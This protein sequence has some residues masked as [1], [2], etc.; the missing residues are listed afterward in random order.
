MQVHEIVTDADGARHGTDGVV[1]VSLLDAGGTMFKRRAIKGVGGG[2][3]PQQVSWL[4]CE[5]NGVRVYQHGENIV[6]TTQD[7]YP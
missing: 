7:L 5:L 3:E 1:T 2:G 6:V 4:V